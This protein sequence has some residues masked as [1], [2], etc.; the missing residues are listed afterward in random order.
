LEAVMKINKAFEYLF[1]MYNNFISNVMRPPQ[2]ISITQKAPTFFCMRMSYESMPENGLMDLSQIES[3]K[4][5]MGESSQVFLREYKAYF[6]NSNDGF[7]N[8]KKMHDCTIPDGNYPTT[9]IK[10][11]DNTAKFIAAIDPSYSKSSDSDFF[12]MGIYM[13]IPEERKIILVHT[14]A[15]AGGDLKDHYKYFSYILKCFNVVFIIIDGSSSEFIPSF[16]E[17]ELAISQNLNL[18]NLDVDL[19]TS[20][21]YLEELSKLKN[22]Y[23]LTTGRIVYPQLFTSERIRKLNE[24]LQGEIDCKRVWFASRVSANEIAFKKAMKTQLPLDFVSE[25]E[26]IDFVEQQDEW[27]AATKNQTALIVVKSSATGALQ[28]D[29]PKSLKNT[30][31]PNKARRDLYTT[32]LLATYGAKCYFDMI[33]AEEAP[34]ENTFEPVVIR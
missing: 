26:K 34:I 15:V 2:D 30:T 10:S 32:L 8:V 25:T 4:A 20:E 23:N 16:N 6:S 17:S 9:L 7:F 13:L 5:S 24:H 27:I 29:L 18:K 31:G 22:Q 1:E 14:Y 21:N 3:A 19:T 12:A 33:F 28:F 11:N